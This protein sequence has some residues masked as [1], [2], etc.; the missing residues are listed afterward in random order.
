MCCAPRTSAWNFAGVVHH[1]RLW[2]VKY[3]IFVALFG[4]SLHSIGHAAKATELAP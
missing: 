2:A 1:G 4:V 3:M